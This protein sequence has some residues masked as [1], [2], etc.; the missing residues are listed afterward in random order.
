[1]EKNSGK[2]IEK[3]AADKKKSLEVAEIL[4]KNSPYPS[5]TFHRLLT[6]TPTGQALVLEGTYLQEKVAIKLFLSADNREQKEAKRKEVEIII[7]L[8]AG[9]KSPHLLNM[10]AHFDSPSPAIVFP[11]LNKINWSER[12]INPT[13]V[14]QYARQIASGLKYM[15]DH[16]IAHRDVKTDNILIDARG[17]AVIIDFG[18]ACRYTGVSTI[19]TIEKCGTYP[20]MGPEIFSDLGSKVEVNKVDV[21][22]YAMTLWQM[23]TGKEPWLELYTDSLDG[24]VEK[25]KSTVVSGKR[26]QLDS[27]WGNLQNLIQLCWNHSPESRPTFDSVCKQLAAGH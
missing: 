7:A 22:A 3:D 16:N 17:R 2:Y 8:N 9:S 5:L 10:C 13:V 19:D 15:H 24:Y 18:F 12:A 11:L 26:P 20:F 21:Y 6:P 1:M 25:L 23:L 14:S 27:R 4:M